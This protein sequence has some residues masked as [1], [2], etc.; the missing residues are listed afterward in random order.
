LIELQG[1]LAIEVEVAVCSQIAPD[2]NRLNLQEFNKN[3]LDLVTH[4]YLINTQTT[5]VWKAMEDNDK[6][7]NNYNIF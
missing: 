7:N 2:C 6:H 4:I 1:R 5:C 3:S